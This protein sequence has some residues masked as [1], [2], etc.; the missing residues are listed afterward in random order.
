[1]HVP[2]PS[3]T[4]LAWSLLRFARIRLPPLSLAALAAIACYAPS[5]TASDWKEDYAQLASKVE[6]LEMGGTAR[7]V[8]IAG[9][10]A[11]PLAQSIQRQVVVGCGYAGDVPEG[12]RVVALAHTSLIA[13][14]SL[15]NAGMASQPGGMDRP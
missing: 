8:A 2:L 1:M 7:S 12:G 4:L 15:G 5:L 9:R 14:A 10:L 6:A 13:A 11:L 3:P